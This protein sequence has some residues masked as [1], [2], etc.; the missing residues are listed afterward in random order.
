MSGLLSLIYCWLTDFFPSLN[1]YLVKAYD[2]LLTLVDTT[3]A[4]LPTAGLTVPI[5]DSH[6]TWVL[7]ATGM[8]P[9]IGIIAGA[10]IT[11]VTLQAIPWVRWG[12]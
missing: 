4:A 5:I 8:G 9:A 7:G 1:E 6:Y 12:S 3:L 11:R 10:L 2:Q